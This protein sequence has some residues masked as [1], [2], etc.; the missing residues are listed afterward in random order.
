MAAMI[1]TDMDMINLSTGMTPILFSC[2]GTSFVSSIK[3]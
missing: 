1:G 3:M 2:I